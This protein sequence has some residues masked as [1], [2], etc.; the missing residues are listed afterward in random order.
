MLC[1]KYVNK[2][3]SIRPVT[4]Q[5]DGDRSID[6][7]LKRAKLKGWNQ[8]ELAE[9]MDVDPQHI[10]NWKRR[11]MPTDMLQKASTVLR[12]SVDELIGREPNG[13]KQ[14]SEIWPFESSVPFDDFENLE[15]EQKLDIGEIV[16]DRVARF[17]AKN[18]PRRRKK[19][20][21]E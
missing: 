8:T 2:L 9:L 18:G 17:K 14:G 15:P 1:N 13:G 20:S 16:E 6:R 7:V 4:K 10:T 19:S 11:G 5:K 21:Q 12:C 3:F